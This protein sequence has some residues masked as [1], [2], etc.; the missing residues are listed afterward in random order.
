[1]GVK[2]LAA[3]RIGCGAGFAGDRFDAASDLL[4]RGGLDYLVL[5]C[6]AERTIAAATLHRLTDPQGGYDPLLERRLAPLLPAAAAH[7]TRL[8]TNLGAANPAAAGEVAARFAQR[9]GLEMTIAVVTG[10]EVTALMDPLRPAQ[11]DGVALADHGRLVAAHAYLGADAVRAALDTG[12]DVVITGRVADPSLF[13]G[14]V[15]HHRGWDL[16]DADLAAHGTLVGHLLECAGQ[17]TGGYFADP[18]LSRVPG[19]AHL[20]FPIAEVTD[21][22]AVITK[23][24]GT[25]G[26][27]DG[28]TVAEQLGYEI[29][30]PSDYVTPDV[31]ADFTGVVIEDQ[32]GDRVRVSGARGRTAPEDLKVSVG[33]QAGYRCEAEIDYCG[34]GARGRAELAAAVVRER[35]RGLFR[36]LQEDLLGVDPMVQPD[37]TLLPGSG[38]CRLSMVAH[39]DDADTAARLGEEVTALYT[40]GPAGGG[41]VRATTEPVLGVVSGTVHRSAAVP[42]IDL[43]GSRS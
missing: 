31:R 15:A 43:L 11:E 25:G 40:N 32:G 28:A 29:G 6:L 13:V 38:R 42:S 7:G 36:R 19:L 20:G 3:T 16:Q 22:D 27:V 1:M 21:T 14:C 26:R 34:S 5:E 41:G 17:V 33:F 23:L 8:V 10:D 12:A 18:P 30:D 24:P 37:G 4:E 2:A 9:L 39:A 35:T